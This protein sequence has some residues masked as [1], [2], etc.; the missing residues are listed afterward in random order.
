MIYG[1]SFYLYKRDNKLIF[2]HLT[3]VWVPVQ[4]GTYILVTCPVSVF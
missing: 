4:V 3:R 2:L 1:L